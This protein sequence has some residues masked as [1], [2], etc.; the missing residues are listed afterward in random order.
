MLP[1]RIIDH[2]KG[3]LLVLQ[4]KWDD[5]FV[6]VIQ[7]EKIQAICL[8][9]TRKWRHEGDLSFLA[10]LQGI[11]I[12]HLILK[13]A[14]LANL[15]GIYHLSSLR[16]LFLG[17]QC[18]SVLD[19]SR[20]PVL[21]ELT[22]WLGKARATSFAGHPHLRSLELL[23]HEGKDI[24]DLSELPN[25]QQ[26]QISNSPLDSLD[27]LRGLKSL[28]NLELSHLTKLK[29]LDSVDHLSNLESFELRV[30]KKVRSIEP[31]SRLPNL[32][33][34]LLEDCGEIESVRPILGLKRL[35]RMSIVGT[36]SIVDGDLRSLES[37]PTLKFLGFTNKR[38]YNIKNKDISP[39]HRISV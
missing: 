10:K 15:E 27:G 4:Q 35:E 1:F 32:R 31:L 6:D 7:Q 17:T 25:L 11:I 38:H 21:E 8:D 37:I 22:I 20:L 39:N 5:A 36:T 29:S 33:T 13:D 19:I 14:T 23:S 2:E 30:C 12:H 28:Q 18:S 3:R 26:L 16:S 9:H 34:I 24:S